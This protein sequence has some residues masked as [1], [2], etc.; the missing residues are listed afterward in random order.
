MDGTGVSM[1]LLRSLY[2]KNPHETRAGVISKVMP[3]SGFAKPFLAYAM[4]KELS[5][6]EEWDT[7]KETE[8]TAGADAATNAARDAE[9]RKTAGTILETVAKI[10]DNNPQAATEI[11]KSEAVRNKYLKGLEGISFVGKNEGPW[12]LIQNSTTGETGWFNYDKFKTDVAALGEGADDTAVQQAMATNYHII[13]KGKQAEA[14]APTTRKISRGGTEI[15]QEWDAENSTWKDVGQGPKWNP[16]AGREGSEQAKVEQT[17]LIG[18]EVARRMLDFVDTTK[19][20]DTFDKVS[21][22]IDPG[23]L[24]NLLTTEHRAIY[25]KVIIEAETAVSKGA[26]VAGAVDAALKRNLPANRPT[27][28]KPTGI[29]A[30]KELE[31]RGYRLKDGKWVK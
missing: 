22:T 17:K 10:S 14:K 26:N 16:K 18:S 21:G 2:Q 8:M 12:K 13:Q 24:R 23:R 31:R 15:D 9:E 11:L 19:T 20:S 4:G 6:A 28:G 7:Q 3:E 1:S 29:D 25:D 5:G 30:A 27:P